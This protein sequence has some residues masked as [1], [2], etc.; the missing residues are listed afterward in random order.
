[1]LKSPSENAF[2]SINSKR[3]DALVVDSGGRPVLAVEYQGTGHYQGTAPGRDAIKKEALRKAGVGY[4]EVL[5]TDDFSLVRL[6]IKELL[7]STAPTPQD[8]P[9][10]G[11]AA[12]A[13][14]VS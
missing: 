7:K 11:T 2:R 14:V 3:V 4:L 13:L 5:H 6:R 9:V 10:R 1:V 8:E 12:P